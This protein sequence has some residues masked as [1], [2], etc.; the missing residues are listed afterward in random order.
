MAVWSQTIFDGQSYP[1][2]LLGSVN[3]AIG[4]WVLEPSV[5]EGGTGHAVT[6]GPDG[7]A[8]VVWS[9]GPIWAVRYEPD[10]TRGIPVQISSGVG[11]APQ[12]WTEADGNVTALWSENGESWTARFE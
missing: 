11:T 2:V 9:E 7:Y 5:L 8:T 10:G 6:T 3:V 1:T 12:V 4:L